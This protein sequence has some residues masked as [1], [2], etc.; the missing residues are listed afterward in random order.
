MSTTKQ[1]LKLD[2]ASPMIAFPKIFI[3][4]SNALLEF[5]KAK[6]SIINLTAFLPSVLVD[7]VAD[8]LPPSTD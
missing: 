5:V 1:I 4:N 3:T 6:K 2:V 7:M 8:Y